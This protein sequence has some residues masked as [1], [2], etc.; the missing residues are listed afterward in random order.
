MVQRRRIAAKAAYPGAGA[1]HAGELL[2]GGCGG[3]RRLALF[4]LVGWPMKL[5]WLSHFIPFP[6]RG[7]AHQRSFNLLRHACSRF[8]TT[9]VAI[10]HEGHPRDRLAEYVS[11]LGKYCK[12]VQVWDPPFS[13]RGLQWWARLSVNTPSKFPFG[14]RA[15]WS[16]KLAAHWEKVLDRSA[17]SLLH[18]DSLDLAL[19]FPPAAPFHKVLNHHN[20]ESA[21]AMR[22]ARLEHN[23]F[24][25]KFLE[26]EASKLAELERRFLEWFD[27]NLAVSELDA[28]VLASG[29]ARA[30]FHVVENGTDTEF[31]VPAA[32]EPEPNSL[33]FS[34]S[35]GWYPNQSAIR[36]FGEKIWPLIKDQ[37]PGARFYVAGQTPPEWLVRWAEG[38]PH[39]TLVANPA[40]IRPWV[41]RATVFVC[42]I[43]D[44]GGT[45]LKILDALAMGKAVVS[46]TIGVEGLNVKPGEHLLVADGP[47]DF[48]CKVLQLFDDQ[49][50][51]GRLS[52][53][54]RTMVEKTYSW[55]VIGGHLD[56][57]YERALGREGRTD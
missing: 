36:Y 57:A 44:G 29:N 51:R 48:A 56:Q 6:P 45:R 27:I 5:L 30:R 53:N 15:R 39:I 32:V 28:K 37:R 54:G 41:A 26:A 22:R 34:G 11:E 33:I 47:Q 52:A 17:G 24:K 38:D 19:Y 16:R 13:W 43:V 55:D 42:P 20:C 21:M 14:C 3:T 8:E 12:N 9:L 4:F 23:L 31:F 25:R 10:N 50:F 1:L 18:F 49:A 2:G 7:G 40:D 46:T 35:L